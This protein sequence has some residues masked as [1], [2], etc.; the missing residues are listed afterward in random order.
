MK[1]ILLTIIL[2]AGFSSTVNAF[3]GVTEWFSSIAVDE[4]TG[5]ITSI[6]GISTA[7]NT[8]KILA[9]YCIKNRNLGFFTV[10]DGAEVAGDKRTITWRTDNNAAITQVWN[11]SPKGGAYTLNDS[12]EYKVFMAAVLDAD[13][14]IIIQSGIVVMMFTAKEATTSINKSLNVCFQK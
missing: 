14:R 11:N 13:Y 2:L 8:K 1:N 3:E 12:A 9:H 7:Q 4:K 10:H 5:D 6:A